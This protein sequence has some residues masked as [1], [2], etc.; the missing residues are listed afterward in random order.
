M[1]TFLSIPEFDAFLSSRLARV[2]GGFMGTMAEI[3]KM[4]Q[5]DARDRLGYYHSRVGPFPAWKQLA[6]STQADRLA[7]GY[8]ANDPLFR[9]GELQRHIDMTATPWAVVVGVKPNTPTS[10]GKT[11]FGD[12]AAWQ[13]FGAARLGVPWIPPRPF[14]GPTL[15]EMAPEAMEIATAAVIERFIG[16][17]ASVLPRRVS[18]SPI[19]SM[20]QMVFSQGRSLTGG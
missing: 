9:S 5:V 13:E 20:S 18:L 2:D 16:T 10:D 8:T 12:I 15:F 14:L 7:Q 11:T 3:G 1:R 6:A 19:R 4:F 17:G